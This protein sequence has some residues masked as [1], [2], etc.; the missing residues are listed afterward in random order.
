VSAKQSR[1]AWARLIKSEW[2]RITASDTGRGM[3]KEDLQKLF[4]VETHF[5][6]P[7]TDEERRSGLGL[8]LAQELVALNRGRL[9]V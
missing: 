3:S 8:I 4:C 5:S 7:G 2:E 9:E 6:C 1:A